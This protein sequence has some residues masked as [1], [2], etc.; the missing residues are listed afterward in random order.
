TNTFSVNMD[1]DSLAAV[2]VITGAMEA[3]YNAVGSIQNLI[4]TSGSDDLHF[5]ISFYTRPK[6]LQTFRGSQSPAIYEGARIYD[7]TPQP[8]SK[9]YQASFHV[10]GPIIKHQLWYA[11]G[12]EL[13]YNST[14]QPAGPPLNQQAPNRVTK[15]AFP[16]LK[17]T[18]APSTQHKFMIEALGDPTYFDY[19]NNNTSTAN[20]T[21]PL[22]SVGRFQGGWKAISEWDYFI[23]QNVD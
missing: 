21:E 9:T 1:Q 16:R 23:S 10:S 17:L 13:D 4:T 8:P 6:A 12:V 14:V 2:Q 20:T 3:K 5:D 22:A 7:Q 11:A 18:W 15:D 19:E